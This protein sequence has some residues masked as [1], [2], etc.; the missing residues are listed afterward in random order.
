MTDTADQSIS[1]AAT[2]D[3]LGR[4]DTP[5]K[6]VGIALSADRVPD[7]FGRPIAREGTYVNGTR[8]LLLAAKRAYVATGKPFVKALDAETVDRAESI[9]KCEIVLWIEEISTF[10]QIEPRAI[11]EWAADRP[12][13]RLSPPTP[14]GC[15]LC[16]APIE[17]NAEHACAIHDDLR[18]HVHRSRLMYHDPPLVKLGALNLRPTSARAKSGGEAIL[19]R[20]FRRAGI[21]RL[22]YLGDRK[23]Q[24]DSYGFDPDW[25][26]GRKIVEYGI[27][28]AAEVEERTAAALAKGCERP[29]FILE[30]EKALDDPAVVKRIVAE[31]SE[32]LGFRQT[33]LET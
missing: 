15:P 5:A 3:L 20:A 6:E 16:A 11:Q 10:Y 8:V 4:V 26:S 27:H 7:Q 12:D 28:S 23:H 14:G 31:V 30:P 32:Y 25:V 21:P 13:N 17:T 22:T 2:S 1:W 9:P 33:H 24:E 29:L 18:Y 19:D